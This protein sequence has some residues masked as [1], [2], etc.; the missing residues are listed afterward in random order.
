MIVVGVS[1]P[2]Q[3]VMCC[4]IVREPVAYYAVRTG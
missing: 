4:L 1:V 3:N 2:V